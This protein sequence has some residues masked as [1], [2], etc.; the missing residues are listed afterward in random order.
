MS[1]LDPNFQPNAYPTTPVQA[2]P[3]SDMPVCLKWLIIVG[4]VILG[5]VTIIIGIVT[6]ISVSFQCILTGII[7]MYAFKLN[8][9]TKLQTKNIF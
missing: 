8:V 1:E 5:F 6:C 9:K 4:S 7:L 3:H 2:S